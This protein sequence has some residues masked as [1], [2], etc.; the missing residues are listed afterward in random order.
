MY[1]VDYHMHSSHSP[2]CS[3]SPENQILA[4]IS[5][6]I[7]EIC[8]TDHIELGFSDW[9][10]RE[11][12]IDRYIHDIRAFQEKYKQI[13]IKIGAEI[14]I[15]CSD[16]D[17]DR[18]IEAV[19]SHSFDFVI[20][21]AHRIKNINVFNPS[22]YEDDGFQ[23][24]C[25]KYIPPEAREFFL[26]EDAADIKR[27]DRAILAVLRQKTP[28]DLKK[29]PD[30]SEGIENKLFSAIRLANSMEQLYNTVKVKR[31]THARIRR[32]A[33]SAFLGL[34]NEFFM[35]PPPYVRVLGFNEKGRAHLAQAA[36]ISPIPI[37]TRV[38]DIEKLSCGA[39]R[40]FAAEC[41]AT[42]MF[43]LALPVPQ[44]CGA[45]YTAK[46]IKTE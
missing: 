14:G 39:K 5:K 24:F 31:Y 23:D 22:F 21:S 38:S 20:A 46:I 33:L 18:T 42:D 34:D 10:Y 13:K 36:G 6:G 3:E 32:L 44:P 30:I 35:K 26:P 12:D 41:R 4:A 40:L 7:D 15:S 29:L 19:N 27:L 8:F 25:K 17:L 16:R 11:M 9:N 37:I 1:Y 45:E 28:E 2:D 43:S